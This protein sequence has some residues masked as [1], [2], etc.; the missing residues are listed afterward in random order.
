M[1]SRDHVPKPKSE[2]LHEVST[3]NRYP[4]LPPIS[5]DELKMAVFTH[6]SFFSQASSK[7]LNTTY[8][9]L[10]FLGDAYLELFAT[11]LV[12]SRFPEMQAG[13]LSQQRELLVKNETLAE[14]ALAYEFDKK[15]RIHPSILD[16]DHHHASLKNQQHQQQQ[17]QQHHHHSSSGAPPAAKRQKFE[18]PQ[19]HASHS[20]NRNKVLGDIFEAYVAAIVLSNLDPDQINTS[21]AFPP[22]AL[23]SPGFATAETFMHSLWSNTKLARQAGR[24]TRTTPSDTAK[25]DLACKILGPRD[26]KLDYREEAP[27]DDSQK[28]QGKRWFKIGVFLYGWGHENVRLGGGTGLSKSEAG[29]MAALDALNGKMRGLVDQVDVERRDWDQKRREEKEKRQREAEEEGVRSEAASTKV[30]N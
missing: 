24:E 4:A 20:K 22:D 10:E 27:P 29:A 9:R 11:R 30:D 17:Q 1:T 19:T 15:A 3:H 14:Y 23:T 21:T 5:N 13:R 18:P 28:K 2:A 25:Q 8:D 7:T 12:Y 26:V 6:P 16:P